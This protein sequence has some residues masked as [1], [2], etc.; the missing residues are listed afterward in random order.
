M[1][2]AALFL[3]LRQHLAF[4]IL[5]GI[6]ALPS[7][8]EPLH[9]LLQGTVLDPSRAPIAGA[10]VAA[11]AEGHVASVS[12]HTGKAGEFSLDLEPGSYTRRHFFAK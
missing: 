10:T 11:T 2:S 9:S 7:Y 12:T 4:A 5:A 6:L 1:L 3:L 8:A